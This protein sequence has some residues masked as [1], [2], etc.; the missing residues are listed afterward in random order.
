MA[1]IHPHIREKHILGRS[2]RLQVVRS[3]GEDEREWLREAPICSQLARAR[4]AHCGVMHAVHPMEI[5]RPQLS[6]SFFLAC[7]GGEGEVLIDGNW[8]RVAHGFACVQPPFITNALRAA[9]RKP[10]EFCWV[11]YFQPLQRSWFESLHSPAIGA[12]DASP[13]RA[14]L[15]GLWSEQ[16]ANANPRALRAWVAL[17]H[18]YVLDF[19]EG[20]HGKDRLQRVWKAVE[21]RLARKWQLEQL[22]KIAGV[23]KEHLRRLTT[24]ALGRTPMQ[25]VTHLRMHHAAKLL[26]T[27]SL[28][29]TEIATSVGFATPFAFSDTFLRWMSVR[30]SE[31]RARFNADRERGPR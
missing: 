25:Q 1:N 18:D 3:S 10:W 31:Y 24:Q 28:D 27:T 21:A 19:S 15:D 6:G 7:F 22:A 4:I 9:K 16:K 17:I 13:L 26:A 11:R 5:I 29:M 30:P 12:F 23:S 8:K 2:T 20:F 14:A